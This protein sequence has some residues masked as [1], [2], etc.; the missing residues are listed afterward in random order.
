[1]IQYGVAKRVEPR[2]AGHGTTAPPTSL[3][4]I[5]RGGVAMTA[6]VPLLLVDGHNLL[7]RACF[8]TP[9]QILSRDPQDKADLTTQF[10]FF[11]LL[12]KGINDELGR[13]PEVIV[14]FDGQDGATHRQGTDPGYKATRAATAE[15]LRPIL[16]LPDVK[17]G[18]TTHGIAWI[19][20]Q[21]AEADDVIATLVAASPAREML[22]ASTDQ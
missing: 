2:T 21:D 17:A 7:F 22:I 13:W 8:G 10:M 12:R 20:I 18:L 19:E 6:G 4:G 9:A 11:A 5:L 3:R 15:A 1:M 16:A 14:V